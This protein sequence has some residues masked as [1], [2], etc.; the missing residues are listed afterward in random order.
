PDSA[1][2][3]PLGHHR[4]TRG[5][6]CAARARWYA[7]PGGRGRSAPWRS[8]HRGSPGVIPMLSVQYIRENTERVKRDLIPRNTT[9]PI[10]RIL[11]LDDDRRDLLQK[12]EAL[13]ATRNSASK[14]IGKTK[15]PAEREKRIAE[16]RKVGEEISALE[17]RLKE[18]QAELD[19]NLLEVP[20]I[21]DES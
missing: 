16:M 21:V 18:V 5:R 15:D 20:N 7:R 17:A 10:D 6:V 1:R 4:R 19:A 8:C 3:P 2:R 14:E 12:V 11:Q 9:A 13:R